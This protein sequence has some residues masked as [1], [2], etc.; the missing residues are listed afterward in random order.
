MDISNE[1][2]FKPEGET[3]DQVLDELRIE[4]EEPI[5]PE[6]EKEE[7][8]NSSDSPAEENQKE[9]TQSSEG[10]KKEEKSSEDTQDAKDE[11]FHKRWEQQRNK[12]K[13]EFEEELD[14]KLQE[15]SQQF[16]E[17]L[18]AYRPTDQSQ[19]VPNWVKKIYGD[20]PDG[21][22]FYKDYLVE[23]EAKTLRL[24]QQIFAESQ[25]AVQLKQKEEEKWQGWVS[26]QLERLT[27]DGKTFD[28]NKLLKVASD[29]KPTD[30]E[31]NID[32]LKAYELYQKFEASEVNSEKSDARKR[33]AGATISS[34]PNTTE[35]TKKTYET[36]ET[37]RN[38]SWYDLTR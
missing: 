6:P 2:I 18:K 32:F 26:D 27:D 15:Q 23:E 9:E 37:L 22:E 20:S 24:K 34:A 28:R 11:P 38:K 29:Y 14:S 33:L 8:D 4:K 10:E 13:R 5:Q 3:L 12:L 30:D 36:P 1:A 35:T 25:Q 7:K 16:E 21:V 17:R 19:Q 31:G